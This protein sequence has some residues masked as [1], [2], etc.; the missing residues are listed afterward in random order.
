MS[1][2]GGAHAEA[3]EA[4]RA[5]LERAQPGRIDWRVA[6]WSQFGSSKPEPQWVVAVGI[7][8]QRGM[9]ELFAGDTT[10]P[11]LLAILVPR[12]AFERIADPARL[13][14]GSLSAVFL[15]QPPARQL[16][17]IRLA[18]SA[19]R[20]VGILVGVESKGHISALEKAA[21]ERGME[22]VVSLMGQGGLFPALQ[23]LLPD[24]EV[25]LALPDPAV[26]NSQTAGN[27]LTAAY[28]RQVPLV[29]FSP[30]YVKAGALLALYSTPTQVGARGGEL[31]RQALPGKSLLPPQWPREFT[32]AANQDVARSLGLALDESQLGEQL[33]QR[34]RP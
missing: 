13:R 24:V 15:D 10:P 8:A 20:K 27:I 2:T 29:G 5:E 3:A 32:V 34:D 18:L 30:A 19:V 6:H 16:E 25:L 31:L 1:D 23:S 4:L 22:L 21:K 17:L 33:R 12:L 9:Q 14:A 11:P 7:A 26:F 28:R